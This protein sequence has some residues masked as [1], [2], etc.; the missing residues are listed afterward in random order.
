MSVKG[1]FRAKLL[2]HQTDAYNAFIRLLCIFT[3]FRLH[4]LFAFDSTLVVVENQEEEESRT[5]TR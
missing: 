2:N 5:L 4:T 1:K 3:H